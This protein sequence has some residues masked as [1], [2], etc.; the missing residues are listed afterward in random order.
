LRQATLT[1][2]AFEK[3]LGTTDRMLNQ[4]GQSL[5]QQLRETLKSAGAASDSLQAMLND[6]RPAARQLAE[7]TLP[8]AEATLRD[9]RA[10]S[11]AL[12][13][14]MEKI[15]NQGAGALLKG[16]TLPDYEP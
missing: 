2:G 14:V 7:S 8:A 10:T 12:R 1:L 16:Q 11:A 3:T 5:A 15:D 13:A 6:S 4:E 9:L